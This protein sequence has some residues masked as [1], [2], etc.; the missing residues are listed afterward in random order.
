MVTASRLPINSGSSAL[1]MANEIFGDGVTVVGA[2]YTGDRNSSGI[3]NNGLSK[4]P[5][6]APSDTGVILSTGRVRDFTNNNGEANQATNTSSN[7]SGPNNVAE[8]DALAGTNTYDAAILDIDFI[9]TGDTMTMQFVFSS[10]EYPEYAG[11]IYNDVVGVWINGVH[12]PLSVGNGDTSVG[13]INDSNNINLYQDNTADQFNT[14]MDGFTITMTL[15][16][17]VNPGVVNSLRIGIADTADSNYDSS[18]LIAGDSVQTVLVANDDSMTMGV[19]GSKTLD[20]LA[21][22]YDAAGGTLTITHINGIAVTAGSSVTLATGQVVTLNS[23]GTL[24]VDTDLDVEKISFTYQIENS[25]GQTDVGFVSVDTVPCFVAGTL[26]RTPD[27]DVPV[28]TLTPGD[29]VMTVDDGP[30]PLR[31][32]GTRQ[33]EGIGKLAPVQIDAS[34]LGEHRMVLLS[35]L[36]RVMIRDTY[37]ELMFGEPEVLVA[38]KDLVNGRTIRRRECEKVTYVHILF[39]RHQVVFSE[40]LATESF[41]PGPQTTKSFETHMI[42]EICEIFPDLDPHTGAGYGPSARPGLRNFETQALLAAGQAA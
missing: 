7:T 19:G 10:E 4:S 29:L 21:N 37:A 27:G 14:E 22:D 24:T 23:D 40:G 8:F 26:I 12:V 2:S 11:S 30:Q 42:E 34:A 5:G 6:V 28:E 36:H 33:V 13:N 18:L 15:T 17:P 9:P 32:I 1:Q 20:V 25:S 35:P 16:I 3:Y 41:L 38:A 31:W 39:D